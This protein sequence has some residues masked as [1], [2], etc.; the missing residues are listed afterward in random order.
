MKDNGSGIPKT[1]F[2]N[3]AAKHATSKLASFDGITVKKG[4]IKRLYD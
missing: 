4:S 3:V 2:A 1:E